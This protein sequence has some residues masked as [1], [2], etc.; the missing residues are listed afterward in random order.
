MQCGEDIMCGADL[1][2]TTFTFGKYP[3]YTMELAA[4]TIRIGRVSKF[5]A[6]F[7]QKKFQT[8][9]PVSQEA[10]V[11]SAFVL[12]TMTC[13]RPKISAIPTKKPRAAN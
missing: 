3:K 10:A 2:T 7:H 1:S 6:H 13:A 9:T 5:I 12:P 4:A 8:E 11:I